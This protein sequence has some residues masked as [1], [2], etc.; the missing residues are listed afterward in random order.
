MEALQLLISSDEFQTVDRRERALMM[1]G[2]DCLNVLVTIT[3]ARIELH[4]EADS[5]KVMQYQKIFV[6]GSVTDELEIKQ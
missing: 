5:N 4:L 2:Y 6:D 1:K 3:K